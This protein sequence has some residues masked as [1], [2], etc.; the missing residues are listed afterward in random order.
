MFNFSRKIATKHRLVQKGVTGNSIFVET[1]Q[2]FD[3]FVCDVMTISL[4]ARDI[5]S[6]NRQI[7]QQIEKKISGRSNRKKIFVS[8]S[9]FLFSSF[10][11]SLCFRIPRIQSNFFASPFK[12][13]FSLS[14]F[15]KLFHLSS[16]A[17]KKE[18]KMS[19][20]LF[21]ASKVPFPQKFFGVGKNVD[22]EKCSIF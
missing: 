5:G 1:N 6:R 7:E 8:V 18:A 13:F 19:Q 14:F 22:L 3:S 2:G 15:L 20:F 17:N 4:M 16:R 10:L 9:L 11:L 21:L 12:Q